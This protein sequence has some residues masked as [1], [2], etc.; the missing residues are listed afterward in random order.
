MINGDKVL[1]LLKTH[2]FLIGLLLVIGLA[3]IYPEF[4][5]TGGTIRSEYSIS[6]GVIALVFFVSGMSLKT[7][8][9]S[10]AFVYFKMI[11]VVQLLSLILIPFFGFGLS[12]LLS[13]GALDRNLVNGIL[14]ALCIP[15]TISSN[16]LMTKQ[17][18]GNEAASLTN[19]VLGSIIGVFL[20]SA[21]IYWFLNLNSNSNSVDYVSVFSKLMLT[22]IAPLI[23]G[24]LVR[25]LTPSLISF[26][27]SYINFS[28]L[29]SC[30]LLIIVYQVFCDTFSTS[31]FQSLSFGQFAAVVGITLSLFLLFSA[32]S[33][34]ISRISFL[35]FS[36]ADTVSIVMCGA[37][38][39]AA[40]GI[41]L[42]KVIFE[43][44]PNIGIISLPLL[45][46]HAEQL[47]AGSLI[48]QY[49]RKWVDETEAS[50]DLGDISINEDLIAIE[51]SSNN[52]EEIM[53]MQLNGASDQR[54]TQE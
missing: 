18:H 7:S 49:L 42:I 24:Q 6:Y 15:T 22:I 53:I 1:T 4:G 35:N 38:K 32:I 19:A 3:A 10:D 33:F 12:K 34:S 2:W 37:T 25:F 5:K 8:A 54:K 17:A 21:L 50:L 29:N 48:V 46:Y 30:L 44:D 9:L 41:P 20:S 26:A 40:L 14:V 28:I 51:G 31:S 47:F 16:V 13:L 45:M 11:I 39:S 43:N 27:Q 36:R 23:M 52:E